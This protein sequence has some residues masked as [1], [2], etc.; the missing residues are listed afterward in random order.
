M[1]RIDQRKGEDPPEA[2]ES[3]IVEPHPPVPSW[4]GASRS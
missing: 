2:A 1:A 4:P 3:E